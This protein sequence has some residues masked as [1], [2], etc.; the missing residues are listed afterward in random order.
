M[1]RLLSV[2]LLAAALAAADAAPAP[3][4]LSWDLRLGAFLQNVA[5]RNAETSRDPSISGTQDSVSYQVSGEGTLVWQEARDR[6]E[7]RL[8]ADYGQLKAT[9]EG[10][11]QESADRLFYSVTY[12]RSIGQPQFLYLNGQADSVFSGRDPDN[13]PLDPLVAK[14]STGYGQR[15]EDLLPLDDTLLWRVGV[16]VHRRW[17]RLDPDDPEGNAAG[18]ELL[19]RYERTQSFD[20]SYFGQVEA[21]SEF[22]DPGHATCAAEVGIDVKIGALL[23][24]VVKGRAY[25]EAAP[26]EARQRAG[27]GYDA[28]SMKEEALLGLLWNI[29]SR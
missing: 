5:S 2:S 19:L 25:Y 17:D 9:D 3:S 8:I 4:P 11:W 29:S 22:D 7:Q 16:Y 10:T 18:P 28:W 15:R 14:L 6:L 23:T 12:E 24:V 20:V 26:E 1:P 13:R 21:F 27:D